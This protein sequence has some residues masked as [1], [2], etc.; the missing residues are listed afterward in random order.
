MMYRL[1]V[2]LWVSRISDIGWILR[3]GRTG[4]IRGLCW[5]LVLCARV[6]LIGRRLSTAA[7]IEGC[8]GCCNRNYDIYGIYNLFM[9]GSLKL[10]LFGVL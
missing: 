5:R 10:L 2:I 8:S 3:A 9:F 1:I 4:V 7:C 6:T